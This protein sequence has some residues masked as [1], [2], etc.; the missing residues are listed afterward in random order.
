MKIDLLYSYIRTSI[1]ANVLVPFV[2]WTKIRDI[3][4]KTNMSIYYIYVFVL[5]HIFHF[6]FVLF[7]QNKFSYVQLIKNFNLFFVCLFIHCYILDDIP[8]CFVWKKINTI[9]DIYVQCTLHMYFPNKIYL[10][11]IVS[12]MWIVY[13]SKQ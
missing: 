2:C 4:F 9:H 7:N 11:A 6:L 13:R 12:L 1:Y 5:K 8:L 10:A 3:C